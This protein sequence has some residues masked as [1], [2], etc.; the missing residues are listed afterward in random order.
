MEFQQILKGLILVKLM[1]HL[2]IEVLSDA[3]Q[4]IPSAGI[5]KNVS[6]EG[7]RIQEIIEGDGNPEEKRVSLFP[8]LSM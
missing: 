6:E 7:N 3:F 4:R 2:A 5:L 8:L 1:N